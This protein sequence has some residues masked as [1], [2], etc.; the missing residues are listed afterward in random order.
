MLVALRSW[1]SHFPIVY[2]HKIAFRSAPSFSR[3]RC[4]TW[5][6]PFQEA[7]PWWDGKQSLLQ[8]W[9]FG[10][11]LGCEFACKQERE[12]RVSGSESCLHSRN[13]KGRGQEWTY[14]S[15]NT[16]RVR[17]AFSMVNL[18][19]PSLPAIRPIARDMW[20]PAIIFTSSTLNDSIYKSSILRSASAS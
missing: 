2:L 17:V 7:Y 15:F 13:M 11:S 1:I 19:L 4:A 6:T 20:S 14:L 18:V 8:L 3:W 9:C 5:R 12:R 16:I 10:R